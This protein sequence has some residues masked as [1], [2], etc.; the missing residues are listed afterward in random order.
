MAHGR[1]DME[2]VM[3]KQQELLQ[4]VVEFQEQCQNM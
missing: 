4:V 3:L 2:N 1:A